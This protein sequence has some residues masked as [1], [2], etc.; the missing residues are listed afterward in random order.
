[1]EGGLWSGSVGESGGEGGNEIIPK[2]FLVV[3]YWVGTGS[4]GD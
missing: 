3:A 1:M 4:S 2:D